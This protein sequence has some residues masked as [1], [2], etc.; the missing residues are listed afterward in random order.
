MDSGFRPQ[1]TDA[2]STQFGDGTPDTLSR[3]PTL[4]DP[5]DAS[6]SA[7]N[8]KVT[9]TK[10]TLIEAVKTFFRPPTISLIIALIIALV[11]PLKALFVRIPNYYRIA[12]APDGLPP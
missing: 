8:V 4:Q 10:A 2:T 1:H 7:S 3:R 9:S 5:A 12:D 11:Q 6:S